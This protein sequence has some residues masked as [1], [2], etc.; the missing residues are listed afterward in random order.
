M[1]KRYNLGDLRSAVEDIVRSVTE[2]S[3]YGE[4]SND[5][6]LA[7]LKYERQSLVTFFTPQLVDIAL[8]KLLN[9]A[10]KKKMSSLGQGE[11]GD[12]F[13]GFGEIPKRVTIARGLK[14]DTANLSILEA[15]Q[16]LERHSTRL[17][18]QD[19]EDFKKL[20]ERIEPH[21]RSD[22][23]TISEVLHRISNRQ[24]HNSEELL[25]AE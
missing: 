19:N 18:E 3:E 13:A 21:A 5:E 11:G 22:N 16:W 17:V 25:P 6:V 20:I 24:A 23:E 7:R 10:C 15:K 2:Q 12:L 4:A 8:T 1:A 9:D 14:K